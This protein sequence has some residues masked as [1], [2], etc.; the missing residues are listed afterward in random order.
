MNF[1][2]G[3][4]VVLAVA[5]VAVFSS[6]VSATELAINGGFET[7]DTTGW[8]PFVTPPST[9]SVESVSPKTGSYNGMIDNTVDGTAALIK[10]ANVGVGVVTPFQDITISFW[11][12]GSAAAGGVH[13][14]ELFSELDGGGVS[15][16]EILGGAPLFPPSDTAWTFY[17]FDRTLGSDVSGG[18]TLQFNAATGANVG[19]TSTLE[20]DDVSISVVPEPTSFAL[21]SLA[22]GLALVGRRRK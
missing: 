7:G 16:T 9:F 2:R 22:A 21:L 10:Q 3:L 14:A 8:T 17:S 13:F 11:A 19:S 18:V 15:K 1:L 12:R 5:S 4:L 6:S 20:I